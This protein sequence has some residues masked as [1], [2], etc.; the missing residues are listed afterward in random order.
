VALAADS[1]RAALDSVFRSPAYDWRPP[2]KTVTWFTEHFRA[3]LAWL[4]SLRAL[5]PVAYRIFIAVLVTVLL[6]I[7]L[8]A[9]WILIRTAQR[10][11]QGAETGTEP[12]VAARGQAWYDAEADRLAREGRF[13]EAVQAAFVALARRLDALGLLQYDASLTPAECAR[14]AR[15]DEGDRSRLRRLVTELYH[16]AFGSRECTADDY[17]RWRTEAEAGWH[18]PAH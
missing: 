17:R 6:A 2:D 11:E 15:L 13:A 8:H 14:A 3:L 4:D 9:A 5:N 12:V 16:V 1:L 7:I 18:A 10:A